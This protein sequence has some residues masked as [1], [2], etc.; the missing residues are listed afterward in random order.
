MKE[1]SVV[2]AFGEFKPESCIFVISVDSEGK[3]CG[4]AACWHMK[5]SWK[6]PLFAVSVEKTRNTHKLIMGSKE[7]VIAVAN[8]GLEKELSF[9]GSRHGN[10]VDK[11]KET[12]LK[13]AKSKFIRSPLVKDATVNLECRL[14]KAVDVG[15]HT[16]FI[17]RILASYVNKSKKVLFNMK[18][19]SGARMFREL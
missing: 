10:E 13:I 16:I 2:K 19:A 5:C 6:P 18:T 1:V 9:F 8:R 14:E 17:G 3:P 12:K 7:F 11:F 4:M 15:D